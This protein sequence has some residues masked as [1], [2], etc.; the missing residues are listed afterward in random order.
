MRNRF[1]R[2]SPE[3]PS[4]PQS[5]F[6]ARS[7]AGTRVSGDVPRY[8]CHHDVSSC[9]HC[10]RG[11]TRAPVIIMSRRRLPFV[12]EIHQC[13]LPPHFKKAPRP[14]PIMSITISDHHCFPRGSTRAHRCACSA[15]ASGNVARLRRC[16]KLHQRSLVSSQRL[17]QRTVSSFLVQR[18]VIKLYFGRGSTRG[19]RCACSAEASGKLT[20]PLPWNSGYLTP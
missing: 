14:E 9:Y 19:R 20:R 1:G 6:Q 16:P 5:I 7:C 12:H 2:V 11:I 17:A 8:Y 15:E 3:L 10:G 13:G 4:G 18:D